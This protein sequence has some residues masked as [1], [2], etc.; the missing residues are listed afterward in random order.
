M[1]D[2]IKAWQ[3]T[4]N[5]CDVDAELDR[6]DDEP[7]AG[8]EPEEEN[9]HFDGFAESEPS[10]GWPEQMAQGT[11]RWGGFDDSKLAAE[12]HVGAERRQRHLQNEIG[13]V[14]PVLPNGRC[15]DERSCRTA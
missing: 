4:T 1:S 5:C 10:L 12:P 6:A 7:D 9:E 2:Q 11:G 14:G 15:R 8:S 3:A 13:N